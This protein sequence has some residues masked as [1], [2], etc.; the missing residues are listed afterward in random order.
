MSGLSGRLTTAREF[1]GVA[2]A[3]AAAAAAVAAAVAVPAVPAV[4]APAASTENCTQPPTD[5]PNPW[6]QQMLGADR[7]WLFTRGAGER[8]A[9]LDSG[10]DAAQ[11]Q[12]AGHIE[13]GFD[14]VANSGAANTD[15]L[16][17]GTEVAGVMVAQSVGANGVYGIAPGATVVPVRVVTTQT[18][19]SPALSPTV[20]ARGIQWAVGQHVD[21]IC[22]SVGLYI[23]DPAVEQAVASAVSAGITVIAAVGDHGGVNDANPKP[24]PAGYPDVL[25]VGAVDQTGARWAN[26][27]YGNFVDLTAPGANVLTTWRGAGLVSANGTGLAAG[28]V[29]AAAAL[30][31]SRWGVAGQRVEEQLLA[32][33]LPAAGGPNSAEFGVGVVNPYGAVTELA[34]QAGPAAP[35]SFAAHTPSQ[36][37]RDW[38]AT[39]AASHRL[40]TLLAASALALALLVLVVALAIPRARRRSWRPALAPRPVDV[41]EPDEPPP[42]ALLFEE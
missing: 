41:P 42:P 13:D 12:F 31:G 35:P 18:N 33:A 9:L 26:S 36:A 20:L 15:C 5:A 29:A 17:T 37:E 7:A 11:A 3:A 10:V 1:A 38:A 23:D 32:T 22:V 28:F 8:I 24:Y 4:A 6:A 27:A 21:V 30:V 34:S 2:F 40:A 25:G 16:G 14:A 19:G 39:W